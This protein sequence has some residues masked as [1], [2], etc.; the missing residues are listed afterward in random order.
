MVVMADLLER[1]YRLD[2][3]VEL[4][5]LSIAA[6]KREGETGHIT[7]SVDRHSQINMMHTPFR[8]HLVRILSLWRTC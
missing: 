1:L 6:A 5:F 2:T 8:Q 7:K 4:L 3:L